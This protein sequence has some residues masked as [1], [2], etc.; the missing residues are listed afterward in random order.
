M[1]YKIII[2]NPAQKELLSFPLEIQRKIAA[3]I[4]G[5]EIN[6]RPHGSKKLRDSELWRIRVS[7]YRIVYN[8]D[9]K[10]EQ[11][12]IVKIARRNEESTNESQNAFRLRFLSMRDAANGK[13]PQL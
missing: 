5:L 2:Y 11:I 4:D 7:N 10:S 8:I 13:N 12:L 3:I 1:A 6:P 9:D